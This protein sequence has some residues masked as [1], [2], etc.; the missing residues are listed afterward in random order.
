MKTLVTVALVLLLSLP[1]LAQEPPQMTP[2]QKAEMDAMI[3]AATPGAPHADLAKMAGTWSAKVSYWPAP[4]A[5]PE[6]SEGVSENKMILGGRYLEQRFNGSMMGAP[7]EGIGYTGYDNVSK[8]Y[9]GTWV[10]SMS[11]GIMTSWSKAGPDGMHTMEGTF[12]DPISGK[13]VKTTDKIIVRG[14]DE[15]VFEM[16]GPDKKGKTYRMMEIV[17]TRKK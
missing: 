3:R 17:Y 9:F 8:R 4:G 16:W 5:P 14:P 11:T 15:H 6:I 10:D 12:W 7:F 13:E 1:V 2:E